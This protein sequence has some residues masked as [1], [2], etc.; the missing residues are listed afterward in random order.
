MQPA[1]G[2]PGQHHVT[3]AE[4]SIG[5]LEQLGHFSVGFPQFIRGPKTVSG[6]STVGRIQSAEQDVQVDRS[7]Q[8]V[9]IPIS[10]AC[11]G[12]G[13]QGHEVGLQPGVF[14]QSCQAQIS[15]L[16]CL[17]TKPFIRAQRKAWR[18]APRIDGRDASM[19]NR[20]GQPL[21]IRRPVE[22]VL[23]HPLAQCAVPLGVLGEG[24]EAF[25]VPIAE[26]HSQNWGHPPRQCASNEIPVCRSGADVCQGQPFQTHALGAVQQLVNGQD[27][28]P[29]AEP[30][31]G[32]QMHDSG[33]KRRAFVSRTVT[34]DDPM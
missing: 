31:V 4:Q 26:V 28:V 7:Q 33:Q 32:V 23:G 18:V 14:V 11:E 3:R 25:L 21:G 2:R 17:H 16:P 13:G 34:L 1:L 12:G 8:P 5:L 9:G 10:F 27:A 24:H 22:V 29:K 6:V 30:A 15:Q 19:P 20:R